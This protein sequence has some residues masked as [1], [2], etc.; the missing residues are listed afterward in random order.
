[1][2]KLLLA[3]MFLNVSVFG[4]KKMNPVQTSLAEINSNNNKQEERRLIQ[5]ENSRLNDIDNAQKDNA[6]QTTKKTSSSLFGGCNCFTNKAKNKENI[7]VIKGRE[8]T[9][10]EQWK[11]E[12]DV[13]GIDTSRL[14]YNDKTQLTVGQLLN[15]AQNQARIDQARIDKINKGVLKEKYDEKLY[16][17]KELGLSKVLDRTSSFGSYN[18]SSYF[19]FKTPLLILSILA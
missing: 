4:M 3:P 19:S 11:L 13:N 9:K 18:F 2:K 14:T 8:I 12:R 16:E 10:K 15:D 5:E 1:M 7:K 17:P 6:N